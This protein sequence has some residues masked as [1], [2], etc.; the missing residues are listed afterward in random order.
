MLERERTHRKSERFYGTDTRRVPSS[1]MAPMPERERGRHRERKRERERE[2]ESDRQTDAEIEKDIQRNG[3][4]Q[5][6]R[7]R[8]T[9]WGQ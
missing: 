8:E 7:E 6:H 5:K 3:D 9:V 4:R 1:F 2:R